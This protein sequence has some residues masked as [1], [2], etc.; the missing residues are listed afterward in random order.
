MRISILLV[1]AFAFVSQ[2][3]HFSQG[4]KQEADPIT[5]WK[6]DPVCQAVYDGVLE[7]LYRDRVSQKIV[8]NIIGK[9]ALKN[10]EKALQERMK[11]SFVLECPLC[12][13]TFAAFFAYQNGK[14]LKKGANAI[15]T[16]N[17]PLSSNKIAAGLSTEDAKQLLSQDTK[18][19]LQGLAPVVHK[20]VSIKLNSHAELKPTEILAWKQRVKTRFDQGK[21]QLSKLMA[22][23]DN[24]KEWSPYWGCAACNGSRQA[25][26]EWQAKK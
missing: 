3:I 24:Y 21:T 15:R 23:T 2:S 17:S 11:R 26:E 7:G 5:D 14:P 22:K 18:T 8:T 20:W 12:E 19:R 10:D 25:A 13:P 1:A 6:K 4:K 16:T 9:K